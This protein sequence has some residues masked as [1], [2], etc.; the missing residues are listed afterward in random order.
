[1]SIWETIRSEIFNNESLDI[2]EKMCLIVL[3]SLEEEEAHLSSEELGSAM[4]CSPVTAK[5]AF[6]SLRLKGYLSNDYHKH[7]AVRR[8][9]NVVRDEDAIEISR[10]IDEVSDDFQPGFFKSNESD[11]D[12]LEE[13]NKGRMNELDSEAERRRQ[14]AAYLLSD[15]DETPKAFVSKKESNSLVDQVI[16]L[17]EEKIS[18]KEANII[19]AFASNDIERIKKKYAIAKQSQVS[20]TI[21]VL[22]N[23]LQKK[24]GPVIKAEDRQ[25]DNTQI[26]TSRLMKMQAY[27]NSR[28]KP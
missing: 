18:Y 20:D 13:Q 28:I 2:Y 27:Q 24:E 14:L 23:E 6:D 5:R 21:S 9:S 16:D 15:T 8:H 7:P 11:A 3:M 17:I 25:V 10:A 1:M 12:V 4:G 22:I 26:N 19:L